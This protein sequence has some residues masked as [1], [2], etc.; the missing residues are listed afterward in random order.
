MA[1]D[2]DFGAAL[3][4]FRRRMREP[5]AINRPHAGGQYPSNGTRLSPAPT[6]YNYLYSRENRA[7]TLNVIALISDEVTPNQDVFIRSEIPLEGATLLGKGTTMEVLALDWTADGASQTARRVAVKRVNREH[8]PTRDKSRPLEQDGLYLRQRDIFHAKV[9][10]MMQEIRI[11]SR[12]R[13]FL[14]RS[15]PTSTVP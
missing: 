9:E 6:R 7:N 11:M 3:E 15:A 14:S 12:V 8:A 10:D 2:G 13:T 5:L 4:N 1:R